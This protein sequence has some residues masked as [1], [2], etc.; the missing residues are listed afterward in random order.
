MD[1]GVGATLR[2]ARRKR[3]IDLAEVEA[4]T[5]IRAR[6]LRAIENEEWESLPG[7]AYARSF[8]RTYG[9]YLGLDGE[10]LAE[11]QRQDTGSWRPVERLPRVEPEPVQAAQVDRGRGPLRSLAVVATVCAALLVALIVVLGEKEESPLPQRGA[12]PAAKAGKG[13]SPRKASK[14]EEAPKSGLAVQ[15]TTN[16]EV[17]VCL[18][19]AKGE[20][21]VDGL[22]L[23]SGVVEGPYRS[24]SFTVSLGNGEVTMTVDGQQASIPPTPNPIGYSI[25]E[26]GALRELSESERPTCT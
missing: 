15:L 11:R 26:G 8:V 7:E 16:A 2:E 18:L 1:P 25:G 13:A 22:V 12:G 6:F 21:L 19:D 5:K 9:D 4:A 10:A 24:G 14:T 3:E 23:E 20:E 17:W